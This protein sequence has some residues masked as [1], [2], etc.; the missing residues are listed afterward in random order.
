MSSSSTLRLTLFLGGLGIVL[1]TLVPLMV[2]IIG[3]FPVPYDL[4]WL[5]QF[6][7][8]RFAQ[9]VEGVLL[10]AFI[11]LAVGTGQGSG[12]AGASTIGKVS[13][14]VFA[15]AGFALS[16]I[17]PATLAPLGTSP[18]VL[19]LLGLGFWSS[20]ALSLSALIVASIVVFRAGVIRGV[21]RWWLLILAVETATTTAVGFVPSVKAAE[22][23]YWGQALGALLQL[24]L[25]VVYLNY[26]TTASLEQRLELVRPQL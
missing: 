12:I 25:G 21:V 10:V 26:G 8:V 4:S 9:L 11:I 3:V 5:N 13:L 6:G 15:I 18:T 20:G 14:I 16:V 17:A 1:A 23:G 22:I 7:N 24:S 19:A 2:E